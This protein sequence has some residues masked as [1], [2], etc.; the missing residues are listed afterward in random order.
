MVELERP[1]I[2]TQNMQYF[3]LLHSDNGYAYVPQFFDY[4]YIACLVL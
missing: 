2:H 4:F 1:Q 3:L